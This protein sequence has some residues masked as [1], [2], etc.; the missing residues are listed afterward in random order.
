[1][2]WWNTR[3]QSFT[4]KEFHQP[5]LHTSCIQDKAALWNHVLSSC[6]MSKLRAA[7][8][9]HAVIEATCVYGESLSRKTCR[10]LIHTTCT[11]PIHLPVSRFSVLNW[12]IFGQFSYSLSFFKCW[13]RSVC[14]RDCLYSCFH[15]FVSC[16]CHVFSFRRKCLRYIHNPYHEH[17]LNIFRLHKQ[18][19]LLAVARGDAYHVHSS[20]KYTYIHPHSL[21]STLIPIHTQV[22]AFDLSPV[23]A[24]LSSFMPCTMRCNN[25]ITKTSH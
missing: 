23:R 10:V 16:S 22:K 1:M 11:V 7:M 14:W 25:A 2:H 13:I 19:V 21:R 6:E 17:I 15:L 24:R 5:N 12:M 8:T 4:K 20:Q 3:K 18:L 9:C